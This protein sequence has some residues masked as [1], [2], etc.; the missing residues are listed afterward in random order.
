[1]RPTVRRRIR[2]FFL[3][4][5]ILSTLSVLP[6]PSRA[7][8]NCNID[9][10]WLVPQ[11]NSSYP[12]FGSYINIKSNFSSSTNCDG[13]ATR[14]LDTDNYEYYATSK[15]SDGHDV[16]ATNSNLSIANGAQSFMLGVNTSQNAARVGYTATPPSRRTR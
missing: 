6:S 14:N 12:Y 7:A 8:S 16:K 2:N 15:T 5:L 1:M 3:P 13:Y 4:V 9:T 11:V 10:P